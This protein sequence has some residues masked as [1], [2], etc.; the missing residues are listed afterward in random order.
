MPAPKI[1]GGAKR[2]DFDESADVLKGML[3]KPEPPK[4]G[5]LLDVNEAR[6]LSARASRATRP[7]PAGMTT[8]PTVERPGPTPSVPEDTSTLPREPIPQRGRPR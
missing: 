4:Q 7:M 6:P 5:S 2:A 1:P 3:E 8:T